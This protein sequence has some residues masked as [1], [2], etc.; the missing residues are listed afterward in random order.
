MGLACCWWA[1]KPRSGLQ[2][3]SVISVRALQHLEPRRLWCGRNEW[4]NFLFLRRPAPSGTVLIVTRTVQYLLIVFEEMARLV[5]S[6]C[7]TKLSVHA[8]ASWTHQSVGFFRV[9]LSVV[10]W[11]FLSFSP[12]PL[13]LLLICS[14]FMVLNHLKSVDS[15]C[16][17]FFILW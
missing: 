8:L 5:Y 3:W 9:L 7:I 16:C 2:C 12:D 11:L 13:M 10:C 14:L 17:S 15:C 1:S 4:M 6:C